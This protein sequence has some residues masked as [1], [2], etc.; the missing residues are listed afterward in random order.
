M[1]AHTTSDDPGRYRDADEVEQWRAKDPVARVEAYLRTLGTPEAFF[2]DLAAEAEEL[3]A[4]LREACRALPE[5]DLADL[6]DL[7]HADE[8]PELAEQKAQ[9]LAYRAGFETEGGAA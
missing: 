2:T 5:P 3:G 1:G 9:Y 7:V 6:F 8:H 4:H